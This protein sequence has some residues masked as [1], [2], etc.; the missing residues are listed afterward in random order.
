MRERSGLSRLAI[1]RNTGRHR[2]KPLTCK[3]RAAPRLVR[4]SSTVPKFDFLASELVDR[5]GGRK[6][7]SAA[8]PVWIMR[9]PLRIAVCDRK[10]WLRSARMRENTLSREA[11]FLHE[12]MLCMKSVAML[13]LPED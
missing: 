10:A 3:F 1:G 2:R 7:L 13:E 9:Y 12:E 11:T 4:L 6:V 5:M 8:Y